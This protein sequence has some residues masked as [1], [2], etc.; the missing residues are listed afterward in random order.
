MYIESV[1]RQN[2]AGMFDSLSHRIKIQYNPDRKGYDLYFYSERRNFFGGLVRDDASSFSRGTTTRPAVT[3]RNMESGEIF[4]PKYDARNLWRETVNDPGGKP[5]PRYVAF[6]P[7]D[8]LDAGVQY[9]VGWFGYSSTLAERVRAQFTPQTLE[10][11]NGT[12]KVSNGPG[13]SSVTWYA[14]PAGTFTMGGSKK[15]PY[16][17]EYTFTAPG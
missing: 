13:R 15:L 7:F 5:D 16:F 10:E 2:S 11:Q 9:E 3:F 4:Y 12:L 14:P 1:V 17:G 8:K 6:L